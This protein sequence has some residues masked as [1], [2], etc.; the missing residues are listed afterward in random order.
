MSD[1]PEGRQVLRWFSANTCAMMCG[2]CYVPAD[3]LDDMTASYAPRTVAQQSAI[4]QA[5]T[6]EATAA[7]RA[8][9]CRTY[10]TQ[11]ATAWSGVMNFAGQEP[12]V[13]KCPPPRLDASS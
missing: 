5:I 8:E 10:S 4:Q 1:N 13:C 6:Q 9:V 7:G 2:R 12:L 11:L 3:K